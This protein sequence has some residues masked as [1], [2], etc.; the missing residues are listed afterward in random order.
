M[1][2]EQLQDKFIICRTP[3][4]VE[5]IVY[6]A[7]LLFGYNM[8]DI[9]RHGNICIRLKPYEERGPFGYNIG[10]GSYEKDPDYG[11]IKEEECS[12]LFGNLIK[13]W[14]HENRT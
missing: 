11:H 7:E 6:W 5:F 13:R 3:D 10:V 12:I 2:K 9:P 1:K 14:K 8:K 4:E